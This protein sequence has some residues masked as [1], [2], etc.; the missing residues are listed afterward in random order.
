MSTFTILGRPTKLEDSARVPTSTSPPRLRNL[1]GETGWRMQHFSG[2]R[3]HLL[4]NSSQLQFTVQRSLQCQ[5]P[6]QHLLQRRV[7]CTHQI[8]HP[9]PTIYG[10]KHRIYTTCTQLNSSSPPDLAACILG[11]DGTQQVVYIRDV[12]L[13]K[14]CEACK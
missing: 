6:E 8:L 13:T 10:K 9:P 14:A 12:Q 3:I 4:S 11:P 5:A 1:C 2:C 7:S